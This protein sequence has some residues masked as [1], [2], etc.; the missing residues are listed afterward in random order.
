MP[1]CSPA[2]LSGMSTKDE[3]I[4][5]MNQSQRGRGNGRLPTVKYR[6]EQGLKTLRSASGAQM[7]CTIRGEDRKQ[8]TNF[9][10]ACNSQRDFRNEK[11]DCTQDP[12]VQYSLS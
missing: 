7:T 10:L 2:S 3:E 11:T 9:T 5:W 1:C 12:A 8:K 6:R 4:S